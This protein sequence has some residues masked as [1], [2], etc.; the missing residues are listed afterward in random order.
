M[1]AFL[2][3]AREQDFALHY[4]TAKAMLP[5]F[6]SAGGSFYPRYGT[7]YVHHLET[8]PRNIVSKLMHDCSLRV[9]P[10]IFN[11]IHNDQMIETTYIRL[12]HGPVRAF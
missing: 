7:F 6:A 8:L 9:T 12:R 10:G 5:Y 4:T 2:R 3:A 1:F 11:A